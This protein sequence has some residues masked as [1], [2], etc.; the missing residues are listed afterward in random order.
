VEIAQQLDKI[1]KKGVYLVKMDGKTQNAV[2]PAIVRHL[3]QKTGAGVYVIVNGKA[4]D[5]RNGLKKQGVDHS[6]ILFIQ[7]GKNDEWRGGDEGGTKHA[8]TP[9]E[10]S[11]TAADEIASGK[12]DYLFFNSAT[13]FL[14]CHDVETTERFM[15]YLLSKVKLFG[16]TGVVIALND[17]H[18][19]AIVPMLSGLCDE[20][21]EL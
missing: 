16:L 5:I 4:D 19:K 9:T 12:Y 21:I 18:S 17:E 15:Q 14:V 7:C 6:K 1:H 10:I 3:N 20:V 8:Y 2:C 13:M 11:L